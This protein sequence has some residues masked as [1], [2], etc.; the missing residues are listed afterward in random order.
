MS[1]LRMIYLLLTITK[2]RRNFD[3]QKSD[4][5]YQLT[6]T[7]GEKTKT[8]YLFDYSNSQIY[9]NSKTIIIIRIQIFDIISS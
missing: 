3:S 8:F 2:N 9:W 4:F 5:L 6:Y 1:F 7:V